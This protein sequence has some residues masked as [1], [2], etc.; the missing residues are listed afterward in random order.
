MAHD[1]SGKYAIVGLG[2][3]VGRFPGHSARALQVEAVRLAIEDA[4]LRREDNDGAI[5]TRIESGAGEARGWTDSFARILGL[6][7]KFYFTLQ[8]GGAMTHLAIVAATQ[9]L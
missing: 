6:P 8:R 5:N 1:F 3:L 9:L 7:T 4:G 2:V